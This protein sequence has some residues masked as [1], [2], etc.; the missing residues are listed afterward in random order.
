[1]K[2][3]L[4]KIYKNVIYYGEDYLKSGKRL[5]EEVSNLVKPYKNKLSDKEIEELQNLM[6]TACYTAQYEGFRLGTKAVINMLI[7]ILSN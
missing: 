5:D 1:M 2:N 6:Y 3:L 7:D 4:E